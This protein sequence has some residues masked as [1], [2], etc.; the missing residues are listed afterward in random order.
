MAHDH[1]VSPDRYWYA[2]DIKPNDVE[3]H[4][5]E[6]YFQ[7]KKSLPSLSTMMR[8]PPNFQNKF[9]MEFI[10][11]LGV[12]AETQV[13]TGYQS[14]NTLTVDAPW[15][16]RGLSVKDR[17]L[18]MAIADYHGLTYEIVFNKLKDKFLEISGQVI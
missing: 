8:N 14:Y 17:A 3:I 4:W 18:V 9:V 7:V 2:E 16:E 12:G 5:P 15:Y 13:R 10:G 6:F 11:E 1:F